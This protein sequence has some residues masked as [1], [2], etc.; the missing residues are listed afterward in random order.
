MKWNS[1]CGSAAF[2]PAKFVSSLTSMNRKVHKTMLRTLRCDSAVP[3]V[4]SERTLQAIPIV[5]CL[6]LVLATA[7][8]R[9]QDSAVP[10][11][12]AARWWK[13]NL[14]THTFWSDGDDFPE[15]V[16]EWYRSRD[17][18]FLA[19]SDHNVLSQG[20]RWMK[21]ADV[22]KRGGDSVIKKYEDRF[23]PDW[24]QTRGAG[25]ELE[26][27]LKPLDE[28]RALVEERGQFIMI[29]SEEISDRAE[30]VPVHINAT[31]IKDAVQPLSGAT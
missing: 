4:P 6:A 5:V 13:G 23:G 14:H 2:S 17:Y 12:P 31:N 11:R 26:Y 8:S 19:L 16:A 30:G 24:V 9:A 10:S 21:V 29:P 20:M 27:R 1:I 7:S 25:A 22:T 15:M 3:R 28:F 18:N